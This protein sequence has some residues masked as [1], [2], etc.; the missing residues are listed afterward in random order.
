[1][2]YF[3]SPDGLLQTNFWHQNDDHDTSGG[4]FWSGGHE[5]YRRR[6]EAML[7][8]VSRQIQALGEAYDNDIV[9]PATSSGILW[10]FRLAACIVGWL[11]VII[12][13]LG[14]GA[15]YMPTIGGM[16]SGTNGVLAC[17]WETIIT[18]LITVF[19]VAIVSLY[20]C[21]CQGWVFLQLQTMASKL[22]RVVPLPAPDDLAVMSVQDP[23][24]YGVDPT[25]HDAG[26]I[27]PTPF[28]G[29]GPQ[30]GGH[31]TLAGYGW[32]VPQT[33][34][35]LMKKY[36]WT[37][38][39]AGEELFSCRLFYMFV[40]V[41][42]IW[43]IML[44]CA[45]PGLMHDL[46]HELN[47]ESRFLMLV[48]GG[49]LSA[50]VIILLG[51]VQVAN[52]RF[53]LKNALGAATA[54]KEWLAHDVIDEDR[55]VWH[56]AIGVGNGGDLGHLNITYAWMS[57]EAAACACGALHLAAIARRVAACTQRMVEQNTQY[58]FRL[59]D[60][61]EWDLKKVSIVTRVL[62]AS[63]L[64]ALNIE[65]FGVA[66][67]RAC[68]STLIFTLT[69][70][71]LSLCTAMWK[72]FAV[73]K[74]VPLRDL[75]QPDGYTYPGL[76]ALRQPRPFFSMGCR[77]L[78]VRIVAAFV[79]LV[80]IATLAIAVVGAYAFWWRCSRHGFSMLTSFHSGEWQCWTPE[81][82]AWSS[83]ADV[84][85]L[86]CSGALLSLG[87]AWLAYWGWWSGT[88]SSGVGRLL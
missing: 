57:L 14:F 31:Y 72:A 54:E 3:G 48:H 16:V 52:C 84:A 9:P 4:Y 83:G 65:Y 23:G 17:S 5:Q 46:T 18:Q 70:T 77:K 29:C 53:L 50:G 85:W 44:N 87:W 59:K 78:G 79:V 7:S 2:A 62:Q 1:M 28:C 43:D 64:T 41:L 67:H 73:L 47:D 88:G 30:P 19:A 56:S 13:I 32:R 42:Q 60:F 34:A 39:L 81:V 49:W 45:Q 66:Y 26:Y 55:P 58:R 12:L 63:L 37:D 25:H 71:C 22:E 51:A 82:Q 24:A 36:Y 15:S 27:F 21:L 40:G 69:C 6:H 76:Y 74:I 61:A 35:Q 10:H 68:T 33:S 86:T 11:A 80:I 38:L 8:K 75:S 20:L